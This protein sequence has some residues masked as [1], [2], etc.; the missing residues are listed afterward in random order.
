[1]SA[2][3]RWIEGGFARKCETRLLLMWGT[4]NGFCLEVDVWQ[5]FLP[6]KTSCYHP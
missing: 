1:M 2:I 5:L 6:R 3:E 4:T